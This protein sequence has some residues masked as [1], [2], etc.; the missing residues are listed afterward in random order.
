LAERSFPA[1]LQ[2]GAEHQGRGLHAQT[3]FRSKF[4]QLNPP[5]GSNEK[6]PTYLMLE[7][8]NCFGHRGLR[9]IKVLCRFAEVQF[10][11]DRQEAIDLPQLHVLILSPIVGLPD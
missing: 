7:G 4:C 1:I 8:T 10:R 9:E 11:G 2:R 6:A 3:K 5:A